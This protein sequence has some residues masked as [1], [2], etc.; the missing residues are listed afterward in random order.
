MTGRRRSICAVA[1]LAVWWGAVAHAADGP[2]CPDGAERLAEYSLFF[3][4]S[5]GGAEIVSDEAWTRFLAREVTPR[6][7]DGLTV[8]DGAGQWRNAGGG[9]ELERSKLLVVIAPPGTDSLRRTSEIAEAYKQSFGQ[10]SVLRVISTVC[11]SF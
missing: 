4:R 9:I 11:A 8:L 5:K 1:A 7:P 6:F 2:A 10:E 3:G